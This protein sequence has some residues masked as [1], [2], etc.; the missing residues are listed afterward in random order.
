MGYS[1]RHTSYARRDDSASGVRAPKRSR[2]TLIGGF[3][4][5]LEG[6]HHAFAS[7]PNFRFHLVAASAVTLVG[8]W[9]DL[10]AGS[11]AILAL[12]VGCVLVTEL[13]N[14]A[15]E[16]LVDLVSPEYHPLAKVVKDLMAGAV[17]VLAVASVLV[18]LAVLGPPLVARLGSP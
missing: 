8:I 18:G 3:R 4:F 10:P 16:T 9:L 17:L 6:L 12:T 5:A 15:A 7:Q 2:R 13:L 14:T 11:W 1:E